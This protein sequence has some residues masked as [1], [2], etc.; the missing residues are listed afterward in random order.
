MLFRSVGPADFA[1]DLH[2]WSGGALGPAHTLRQS[3]FLRGTNRSRRVDGLYYAGGSSV[4]GIGLP[5][6]LISA[7]NV[8]KRVRGDRSTGPLSEPEPGT[9]PAARDLAEPGAARA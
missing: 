1:D 9:A 2:S 7:E 8:L 6:C 3:A 5:M 4:P